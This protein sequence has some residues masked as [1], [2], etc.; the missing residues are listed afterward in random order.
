MRLDA[1]R[2][3]R[4]GE[5]HAGRET[6]RQ[7]HAYGDAFAMDEPR[8]I[9]LHGAFQ[10]VAKRMAEIEQ[11]PVA[12]LEFVARH[13]VSL[14]TA[15]LCDRLD[16]RCAAVEHVLP[17]LFQPGE[18]IRPVDKAVF[19]DLGIAGAEFAQRQRAQRFR[20]G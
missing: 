5:V 13:N 10:R 16:T 17:V 14:G 18:E 6:M 8:A 11:G 7:R 9:I 1:R 20:V 12:G 15:G 4:T 2:V 19:G 3:V